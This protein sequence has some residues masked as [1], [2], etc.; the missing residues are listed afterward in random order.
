MKKTHVHHEDDD[1]DDDDEMGH[2]DDDRDGELRLRDD[3]VREDIDEGNVDDENAGP[4]T[5]DLGHNNNSSSSNNSNS[6]RR[7]H[8]RNRIRSVHLERMIRWR[9][10]RN[11]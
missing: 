6:S 3:G 11:D 5:V 10:K 7:H 4:T 8:R 1:D 9:W 2:R